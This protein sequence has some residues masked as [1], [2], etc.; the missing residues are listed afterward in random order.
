[1]SFAHKSERNADKASRGLM[2]KKERAAKNLTC[3]C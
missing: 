2:S 1:L 3:P